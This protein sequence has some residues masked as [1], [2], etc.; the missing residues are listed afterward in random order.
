MAGKGGTGVGA[1]HCAALYA[2]NVQA[3]A[4]PMAFV[5]CRRAPSASST[6]VS[7]AGALGGSSSVAPMLHHEPPVH[8]STLRIQI[9]SEKPWRV[10]H[11][12]LWQLVVHANLAQDPHV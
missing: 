1:C 7:R 9:S 8:A 11:P 12:A 5:P 10:Q 6:R 3:A 2:S 4:G